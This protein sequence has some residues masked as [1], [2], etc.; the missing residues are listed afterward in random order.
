MLSIKKSNCIFAPFAKVQMHFLGYWCWVGAG[1]GGGTYSSVFRLSPCLLTLSILTF[2]PAV[3][4]NPSGLTA[5]E[6]RY[7]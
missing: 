3:F 7:A 4:A 2:T 5:G 6:R 1:G